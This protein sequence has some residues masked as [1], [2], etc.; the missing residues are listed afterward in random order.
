MSS[1]APTAKVATGAV[2][3]ALVTVALAAVSALGVEVPAEVGAALVVLVSFGL[4]YLVTD[5]RRD[6]AG[7]VR[8]QTPAGAAVVCLLLLVVVALLL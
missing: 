5:T 4:S 2:A 6:D 8:V 7:H 1:A 3:G